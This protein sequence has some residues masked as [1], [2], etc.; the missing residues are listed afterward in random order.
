MSRKK[1]R[2]VIVTIPNKVETKMDIHNVK[3]NF[4]AKTDG[5]TD[6]IR[7]MAKN[8]VTFC[9]GPAGTGKSMCAI[10]YACQLFTK[11]Q[12][13][14]IIIARPAIEASRKGLG[15]LPG[16]LNNKI[17]PYLKPAI[18]HF[19]KLLGKDAYGQALADERIVFE[20]LEYMRG[21]TYDRSFMILEEAQNCTEEQL[22]MFIT[23][24]G[25]D[26]KIVIN[27]DT[28]QTDLL[29]NRKITD[30]EYVID[31]CLSNALDGF[32]HAELTDDDIVRNQIIK[33]FMKVMRK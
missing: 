12:I 2:D 19:K 17:Q 33:D 3:I 18:N 13:D 22:V 30:F 27:G 23:R 20:T 10:A 4:R 11:G 1:R 16:D 8:V 26:S 28:E 21:N 6:Y 24:I 15:F 31:R 9:T 29:T 5:Q 32:V 14:N 7:K 25:E